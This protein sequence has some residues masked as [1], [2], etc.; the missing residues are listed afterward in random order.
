MLHRADRADDHPD[1]QP[2]TRDLINIY[3]AQSL[4][5]RCVLAGLVITVA[6]YLG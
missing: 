1:A 2:S 6:G 3:L 5:V 4:P